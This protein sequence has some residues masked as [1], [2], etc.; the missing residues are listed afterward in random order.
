LRGDVAPGQREGAVVGG[1]G[2]RGR[3]DLG[4]LR[5]S[6]RSVAGAAGGG[7]GGG[8][9]VTGRDERRACSPEFPARIRRQGRGQARR[10]PPTSGDVC[11]LPLAN[12]CSFMDAAGEARGRRRCGGEMGR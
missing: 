10:C 4:R 2:V 6:R 3:P 1:A 7:R 9:H 5:A 12:W 11:D 8:G